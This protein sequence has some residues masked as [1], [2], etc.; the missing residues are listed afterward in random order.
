GADGLDGILARRFGKGNLGVYFEA[1]SDMTTMGI[2]PCVFIAMNYMSHYPNNIFFLLMLWFVLLFY[3]CCAFIRLA[4][5]HPLKDKKV[6]LG[7]P[8]S[9]ATMFLLSISFLTNSFLFIIS[10]IIIAA[11]LMILPVP[12]PK[13][14]KVMNAFTLV[15]I[16]LTI[17]FG[18]FFRTIY[19][20]LLISV[21]IYLFGGKFYLHYSREMI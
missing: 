6:F 15:I 10:A 1:M 7:L 8:A 21:L 9:A 2:A 3:L 12:F 20:V 19:L 11:C 16:L 4:S 18:F 17:I 13:P 14:S 5:F